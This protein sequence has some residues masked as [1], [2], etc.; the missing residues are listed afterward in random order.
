MIQE[1]FENDRKALEVHKYGIQIKD[2]FS[3]LQS[4]FTDEDLELL[5]DSVLAYLLYNRNCTKN[6]GIEKENK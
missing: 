1:I 3:Y 5:I 2:K 6:Y 4:N